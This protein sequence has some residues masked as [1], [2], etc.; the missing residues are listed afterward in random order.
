MCRRCLLPGLQQRHAQSAELRRCRHLTGQKGLHGFPSCPVGLS[1]KEIQIPVPPLPAMFHGRPPPCP[2][3]IVPSPPF[4]PMPAL[5]GPVSRTVPIPP[6]APPKP[7]WS[8]PPLGAPPKFGLP[9]IAAGAAP[10]PAPPAPAPAPPAPAPAPPAPAPPAPAPPA[11]APPALD[12]RP[13][14][15]VPAGA[16]EPAPPLGAALAPPLPA[17]AVGLGSSALFGSLEQPSNIDVAIVENKHKLIVAAVEIIGALASIGCSRKL[18]D[19]ADRVHRA[20][21]G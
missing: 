17:V 6:E 14:L 5:S 18:R 8:T 20:T 2:S 4:P 12:V 21:N 15:D 9:A 3:R 13:A 19:H 10:A 11:P 1:Q 7:M 16:A